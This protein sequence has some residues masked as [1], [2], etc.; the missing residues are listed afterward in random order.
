MSVEDGMSHKSRIVDQAQ[1]PIEN[2]QLLCGNSKAQLCFCRDIFGGAFV[3]Q[4]LSVLL[5]HSSIKL[6]SA[7]EKNPKTQNIYVR[8]VILSDAAQTVA[9]WV[10]LHIIR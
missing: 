10:M 3:A 6:T 5:A 7:R 1:K 4:E 9:I 2:W 8:Y